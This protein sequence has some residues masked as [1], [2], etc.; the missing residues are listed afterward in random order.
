[1]KVLPSVCIL[2]SLERQSPPL[3]PRTDVKVGLGY[4]GVAAGW[5]F[6]GL[7]LPSTAGCHGGSGL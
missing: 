5:P 3:R 6:P 7:L 4:L 2:M 1:M